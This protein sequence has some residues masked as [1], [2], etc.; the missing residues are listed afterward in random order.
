MASELSLGAQVDDLE[1]RLKAKIESGTVAQHAH[2]ALCCP[3]LCCVALV[4]PPLQRVCVVVPA[5]SGFADVAKQAT[6]LNAVFRHFNAD[7]DGYVSFAE[8][9]AALVRL[10]FVGVAKQVC[11][12]VVHASSRSMS[13]RESSGRA[14]AAVA[15]K[16][17]IVDEA[18]GAAVADE[19]CV[20]LRGRLD[21][22]PLLCAMADQG[23]VRA[24]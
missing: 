18:R 2:P 13:R 11:T 6:D 14:A 24:V 9:Q 5:D 21:V 22:S 8:F 7:K 4:W 23:A 3:A 20:A 16:F 15:L 10:N 19:R 1:R 17:R 12:C